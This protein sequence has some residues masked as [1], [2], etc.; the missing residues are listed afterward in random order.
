MPS[1][2][3]YHM[4]VE[5]IG[6]LD[7]LFCADYGAETK[8]VAHQVVSKLCMLDAVVVMKPLDP[9]V[10][11]PVAGGSQLSCRAEVTVDLGICTMA[12]NLRLTG[13]KCRARRT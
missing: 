12:G 11:V 4:T 5:L 3:T 7:V 6:I 9:P 10:I 13:V 1:Q 2:A 8:I